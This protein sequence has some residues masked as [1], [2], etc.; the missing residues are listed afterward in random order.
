M[1][2]INHKEV[3]VGPPFELMERR[4]KTPSTCVGIVDTCLRAVIKATITTT[5]TG[6]VVEVACPLAVL[7]EAEVL[8]E[9]EAPVVVVLEEERVEVVA[10]VFGLKIRNN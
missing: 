8:E 7:E 6:A 3:E 1:G 10:L 9:V 4:L 5:I 2:N